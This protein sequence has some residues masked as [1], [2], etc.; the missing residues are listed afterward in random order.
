MKY[1]SV[2]ALRKWKVQNVTS[3]RWMFRGAAG[4]SDLEPL[5]DWDV[6]RNT[7]FRQ[8]FYRTNAGSNAGCRFMMRLGNASS[9]TPVTN[10][11]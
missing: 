6:G 10:R 8:A 4:L 5:K 9:K 1:T 11:M 2:E 3:M 7:D